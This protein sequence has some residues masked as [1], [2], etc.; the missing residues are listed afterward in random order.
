[1]DAGHVCC[2]LYTVYMPR[3]SRESAVLT[4]RVTPTLSRRLDR[5]A[6]RQRLTRSEAARVI[7]QTALEGQPDDDLAAEARRQSALAA[8][9]AADTETLKFIAEVADSRGWK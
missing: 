9:S 2:S 7:L 1:L 3:P 4:I 5:E 6:R 8:E